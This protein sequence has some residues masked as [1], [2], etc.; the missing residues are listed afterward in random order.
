MRLRYAGDCSTCGAGLAAGTRAVYEA[1]TRTVRCIQCPTPPGPGRVEEVPVQD[2]VVVDQPVQ[3]CATGSA[4]A[5]AR[6]EFERRKAQRE[7]RIRTRHPR[8]GGL[9]LALSEEPQATRAWAIGADGEER[10]GRRLDSLDGSSVRV[11]H[12]RRIPGTRA[13]I[14][15]IVTTPGGV[16]VVDAK[17]YQGR[18][19]LRV[20]GGLLR[21]RTEKLLVGRRDCSKLVDG[22]LKQVD[23]VRTALDEDDL[24]VTGVLCFVAADWPLIGGA[25]RTRGVHVLWPTKLA[26]LLVQ[27]GP[28]TD[29]RTGEIHALLARTFPPA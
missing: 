6:R 24:P 22:V 1:A 9:I 23:L 16:F 12:D 20:E 4:G 14:D 29:D 27:P 3:P 25:F 2:P 21:A 17:K 18:P 13:N 8:A 7:Q 5:S 11:L 10:L 28:L 15:H 19:Q 26:S